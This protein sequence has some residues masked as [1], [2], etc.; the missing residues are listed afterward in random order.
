M[1]SKA[2]KVTQMTSKKAVVNQRV[3]D[4]FD[5]NLNSATL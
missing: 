5:F 2:K 1:N 3:I 4:R